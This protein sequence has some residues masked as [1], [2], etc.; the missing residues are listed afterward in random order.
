MSEGI[1][2]SR[3][4]LPTF[5]S[6]RLWES[7]ASLLK[8]ITAPN[9][10]QRQK[11][12]QT[13]ESI[14]PSPFRL[15]SKKLK[16]RN[17]K[18]KLLAPIY[19]VSSTMQPEQKSHRTVREKWL[20]CFRSSWPR[21]RNQY[22]NCEYIPKKGQKQTWQKRWKNRNQANISMWTRSSVLVDLTSFQ[23]PLEAP[24]RGLSPLLESLLCHVSFFSEAPPPNS[25]KQIYIYGVY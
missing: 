9:T 16:V 3:L 17:H 25:F 10:K 1:W 8:S 22:K 4:Q 5:L 12:P 7:Y 14:S 11:S 6:P 13:I 21:V 15:I 23:L 2:P 20:L 24:P 19:A 18:S